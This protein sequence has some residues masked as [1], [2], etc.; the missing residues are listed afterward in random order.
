MSPEQLLEACREAIAKRRLLGVSEPEDARIMLR[1][2]GTWGRRETAR[3]LGRRGG[4]I[5][6]I[7]TDTGAP[8]TILVEFRAAEIIDYV[9]Q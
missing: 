2:K 8:G 4:P 5:G 6:R 7:V 9:G 3:L 1:L